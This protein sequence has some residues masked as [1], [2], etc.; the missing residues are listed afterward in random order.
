MVSSITQSLR[1]S[2]SK[3]WNKQNQVQNICTQVSFSLF[4]A[5]SQASVM[6]RKIV[7]RAF[8]NEG[9]HS[10]LYWDS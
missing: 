8:S 10:C 7:L 6:G 3:K 5:V 9:V 2:M 4:M 1:N